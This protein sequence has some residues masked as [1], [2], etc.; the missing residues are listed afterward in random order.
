MR[1][2]ARVVL[3]CD[4]FLSVQTPFY[5]VRLSSLC[6]NPADKQQETLK[7]AN[8]FYLV[9]RRIR[10]RRKA[11]RIKRSLVRTKKLVT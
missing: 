4:K 2:V 8:D 5:A 10:T 9:V 3:S 7:L 11:H 1:F 6:Y